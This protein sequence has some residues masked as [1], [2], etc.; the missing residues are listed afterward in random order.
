M[1]NGIHEQHD[2]PRAVSVGGGRP[3]ADAVDGH[4][5]GFVVT[6]VAVAARGV[7]L[8]VVVALY[9][10]EISSLRAPRRRAKGSSRAS[11]FGSRR[12]NGS[13]DHTCR[14]SFLIGFS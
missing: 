5:R 3:F 8:V 4:D 6:G 2:S 12:T 9:P 13:R 11:S 14:S 7:R 10:A 1:G